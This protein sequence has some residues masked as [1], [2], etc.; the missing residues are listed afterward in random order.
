MVNYN[1]PGRDRATSSSSGPVI[2]AI[3]QGTITNWNDAKIAAL[4]PG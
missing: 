1:V 4:N 3:Y 2:A